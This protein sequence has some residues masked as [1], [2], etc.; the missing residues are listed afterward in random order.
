MNTQ[1]SRWMVICILILSIFAIGS[2]SQSWGDHS[3][4]DQ[5][6]QSILL[7]GYKDRMIYPALAGS[8]DADLR[9]QARHDFEM[10][11]IKGDAE[12]KVNPFYLSKTEVRLEMFYP[13]AMGYG[14]RESDY[15]VRRQA[16]FRPSEYVMALESSGLLHDMKYPALAMSRKA[17]EQYCKTLSDLTGRTY[18]LPTE[19]EWEYA[20][21]LG[22]GLSEEKDAIL[23][24]ARF[25]TDKNILDE[26]PFFHSPVRVGSLSPDKLGLHD[27]LGN[28][29]E[30]V[31]DTGKDRVVR[32][33]HFELPIEKMKTDWRA[34]EDIEV[35]NETY[36]NRPVPKGMYRDFPYTGIR[37]ACDADQAPK[38]PLDTAQSP[39]NTAP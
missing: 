18:R 21:K 8:E 31:T 32:G 39:E 26:P 7:E 6:G 30:W 22:G 15:E 38:T 3:K 1:P 36:P 17:A 20:L 14:L 16:G 9:Q 25:A 13:W 4:G 23:K 24:M 2:V 12:A 28:A 11:L 35:W 5:P 27:M 37:L 29:A 33:G 34:V 10:V 19:K